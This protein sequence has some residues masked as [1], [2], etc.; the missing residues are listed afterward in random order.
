MTPYLDDGDV[1]LHHGDAGQV[2][3]TP[4]YDARRLDVL[5]HLS[6]AEQAHAVSLVGLVAAYRRLTSSRSPEEEEPS[7]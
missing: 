3:A 5:P 1:V 4:D 7:C 2:L 6:L